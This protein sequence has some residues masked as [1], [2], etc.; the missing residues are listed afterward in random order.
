MGSNARGRARHRL[1]I[2]GP[3]LALI[4]SAAVVVSGWLPWLG[5]G[6]GTTDAFD[7]PAYFLL[8]STAAVAGLRLGALVV[9][10]GAVGIVGALVRSLRF[11]SILS[12]LGAIALGGL[13]YL[14]TN[15]LLDAV[16]GQVGQAGNLG[17]G[18]LDPGAVDLSAL[19]L[20]DLVDYGVYVAIVG[21]LVAILGG[22][23]SLSRRF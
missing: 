15:Y 21:G 19:D 14:Q 1:S 23:I 20:V 4:G 5:V 10:I 17:L 12:G 2:V 16:K 7:R 22:V 3:A 8:D 6:G 18:G 13:F 11:L 9:V